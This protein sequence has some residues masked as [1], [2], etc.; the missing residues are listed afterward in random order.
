MKF[1]IS[2]FFRADID[3]GQGLALS[4]ILSALYIALTFYIYK[5][6]TNNLLSPISVSIVSLFLR[7]KTTKNQ[8]QIHFVATMLFLLFLS[9]L[10]L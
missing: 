2:F 7:K 9:S 5:K 8:I 3:V 6:R 10:V 1:V 4:P